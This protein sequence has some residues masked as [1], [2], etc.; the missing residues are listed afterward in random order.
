MLSLQMAARGGLSVERLVLLGTT[1]RFTNNEEWQSG[2]PA[3]QVNALARNLRRRF[4]A[5][6][7]D[8]FALAFADENISRERL[9]TIRNFAVRQS[10]M[11]DQDVAMSFLDLLAT[12][13]QR[14]LL[15]QI[16]QPVLVIHGNLD[17][18]A[19]IAA[20]R[21]LAEV[22][23]QGRLV[24]VPGVGHSPLLSR[25]EDVAAEILEFC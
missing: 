24:E 16:L 8:F 23:P 14:Q 6:L 10:S 22:L 9:R 17:R 15:P 12:Q 7:G 18:I 25:P 5:T 2:L 11:P 20:G 13:D 21:F 1:P 4:E 3:G 19:P